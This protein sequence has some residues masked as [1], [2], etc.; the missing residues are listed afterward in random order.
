M[1]TRASARALASMARVVGV[2]P[3]QLARAGRQDA[4]RVLDEAL[5]REERAIQQPAATGIR[6]IDEAA[7]S[8]KV[9]PFA[10]QVESEV[11][12]A[13]ARYG[14]EPTGEQIF[15]LGHEANAWN[16]P[17]FDREMKVR[18]IATF[19]LFAYQNRGGRAGVNTG[20]ILAAPAPAAFP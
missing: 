3:A 6:V 11:A 17:S 19:R 9:A 5:R 10:W 14:P 18:L 12:R 1:P 15:G 7:T 20:L 4:A 16:S 2:R 13:E 8:E